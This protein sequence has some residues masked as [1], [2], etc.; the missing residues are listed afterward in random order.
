MRMGGTALKCP[1]CEKEMEQGYL[2]CR[3]GVTW[4]PKK[5]WVAAL[6]RLG[7]GA[8]SLQN[9]PDEASGSVVCAYLCD[10]CELVI[11]PYGHADS[12]KE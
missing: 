3:D 11:V 7:K 10:V 1:Y 2:Q 6:S 8:V 4:T 5:Q 12:K 9:I